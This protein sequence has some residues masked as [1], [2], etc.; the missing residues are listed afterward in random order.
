MKGLRLSFH[1]VLR[2]HG[3]PGTQCHQTK[4]VLRKVLSLVTFSSLSLTISRHHHR[5]NICRCIGWIDKYCICQF[6]QYNN[7]YW[8]GS[9]V[10]MGGLFH[11]NNAPGSAPLWI[12]AFWKFN[13]ALWGL[14]TA[15]SVFVNST[16]IT[17]NKV[18]REEAKPGEPE[19]NIMWVT[20]TFRYFQYIF[21]KWISLWQ[22]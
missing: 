17:T 9:T 3:H 10:Y 2:C 12:V 7:K 20:W 1:P 13:R 4:R 11:K 8:D 21:I 5:L 16:N 18:H 15:V 22:A 6:N 19:K 14:T